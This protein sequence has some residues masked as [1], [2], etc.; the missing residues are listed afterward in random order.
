[1]TPTG[2]WP[3]R[4]RASPRRKRVAVLAKTPAK[5]VVMGMAGSQNWMASGAG[6]VD[7]DDVEPAG[8]QIL[9]G[10]GCGRRNGRHGSRA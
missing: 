6:A 10:W 1:M 7:L 3:W 5:A 8:L 9:Q 2:R 4:R